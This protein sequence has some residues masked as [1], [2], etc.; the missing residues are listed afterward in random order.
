MFIGTPFAELEVI[1]FNKFV[2]NIL[3]RSAEDIVAALEEDPTNAEEIFKPIYYQTYIFN[4]DS[5]IKRSH[6]VRV[7]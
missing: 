5:S 3:G 6:E 1:C 2:T 4:L 7:S